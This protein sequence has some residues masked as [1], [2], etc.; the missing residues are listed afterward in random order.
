VPDEVTM[1]G[2]M[3]TFD[4]GMRKETQERVRRTAS[5]IAEAAG[6]TAEVRIEPGNTITF[7]DRAL[8]ARMLPS[9]ERVS[10]AGF[11]P[12]APVTTTSEDFSVYQGK[13]PGVFFFLGVAPRD[14]DPATVALNHSP[15]FFVDERALVTGVRALASLALDYLSAK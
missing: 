8:T 6:A 14:A 10:A 15:R 9:L 4:A 7:N 5:G 1:T 2:T 11:D 3:R 13:V 12:N